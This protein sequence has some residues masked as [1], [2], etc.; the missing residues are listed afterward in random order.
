MHDPIVLSALSYLPEP[1]RPGSQCT[2]RENFF[3]QGIDSR[4]TTK[5]D[6]KADHLV[7]D[8]SRMMARYS[9]PM[10]KGNPAHT[11][12]RGPTDNSVHQGV[13][14]W[15]RTQ[16]PTTM[17]NI[18]SRGAGN[19]K[20]LGGG[21]SLQD[22]SN[23]RNERSPPAQDLSQRLIVTFNYELPAGRGTAVG[24]DWGAADAVLGGWT[25]RNFASFQ[26]GMPLNLTQRGGDI[27]DASQ[28]PQLIGNS[29][30]GGSVY[31]K[32]TP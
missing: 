9:R 8:K 19:L 22:W 14:E 30:P 13:F 23:P 18:L 25:V 21:A 27:W 3:A 1:N 4:T 2:N 11:Y 17:I 32:L 16:S 5:N 28:R 26:C 24:T 31:D 7:N 10:Y 15:N 12:N 29:D 6:I 20:W